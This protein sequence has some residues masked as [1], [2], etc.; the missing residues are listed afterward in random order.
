MRKYGKQ[1]NSAE[2]KKKRSEAARKAVMVRW[3]AYHAALSEKPIRTDPPKEFVRI[4]VENLTT[5]KTE[6]LL[7]RPGDRKGR[8]EIDVNGD[9]WKEC[10]WTEA[11]IR[12]RK[13]CKR[14]RLI[15]D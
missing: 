12:V 2:N 13:S 14:M 3:N 9:F 4:T 5:S 1:Y 6:I 10:G 7:F 8:F 11:L 15:L